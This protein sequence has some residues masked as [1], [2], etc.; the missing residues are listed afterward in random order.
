MIHLIINFWHLKPKSI[1]FSRLILIVL[2][3]S[4]LAACASPGV[5]V[6]TSVSATPV[7]T[8]T[9]TLPPTDTLTP[10]PTATTMP[11]PT[12]TES[13]T[14]TQEPPIRFAVIGDYG[15][16]GGPER[17]VA[18]LVK[19]WQPDFIITTGDNNYPSGS[20]DTI[21][22]TI[23]QFYHSF[24]SPYNGKFGEGADINRFFPTLGNHDWQ[25]DQAAPYLKYF[26]LPGNERYYDFVWGP[27]HFFALD[28][29]SREPDG[30]SSNSIQANWLK[31][32]L[33]ASDS[34]W[35]IVYFHQPPY[36]SGLHGSTDWMRWPFQAWGASAVLSGHDHT[37]ERILHD[38]FPYFVNGLGGGSIYY[39]NTPID[40][41]QVRYADDYG[42]MLVSADKNQITFQ[43][44]NR[45]GEVI[46]TYS[47]E[48]GQ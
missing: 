16:N 30:V 18:E 21:D 41:S 29:D 43:F 44:I 38:G 20:A 5:P 46:D 31:D 42:A 26:T 28:A 45:K 4:L 32:A 6:T 23:G 1:V 13:P 19:S 14:P 15:G 3:S 39:F 8:A 36:S 33:A 24:I 27:V 2:I 10:S 35:N 9:F 48:T 7:P 11:T 40:G 17:D 22:L 12:P 25:T 47:L 34:P 37:Y